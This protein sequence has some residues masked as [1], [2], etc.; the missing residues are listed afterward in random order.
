MDFPRLPRFKRSTSVPAIQ[1]TERDRTIIRSIY[2]HRFLRSSHIIDLT[3]G[4]RQA[5]LRRLQLLYHHGYLERPRAQI[6][7]YR[8]GGSRHMVYGLGNK[9]AAPLKPE[10][11][12][13]QGVRWS[14]K[15]RSIRRLFF[16]HVIAVS[17][18]MVALELACRKRSDV[19]LIGGH[20]LPIPG[21]AQRRH[22]FKW[23]VQLNNH[24][25][26]G[27]LPDRVFALEVTKEDGST[28]RAFFFLE[29]DRGTMPIV[30]KNLSQTSFY[31]KLLAYEATW[32][33]GLHR[34][35]FGFHRFR[36]LTVTTSAA[37]VKSLVDACSQLKSGHGLFLFCDQGTLK[38]NGD[39]L[40][41]PWKTGRGEAT[42]ILP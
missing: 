1:L 23:R 37:R 22:P 33:S 32:S 21:E 29:V 11:G 38:Q 7:Y 10:I 18:V 39:I 9:G 3:G 28:G 12:I 16:E 4:S 35:K 20:D 8:H 26:L 2:Q 15:N 31:R 6:E 27:I 36:V 13:S 17:D 5:V 42:T 30:R 19:R 41:V 25:K 34:L 14:E 40:T 24:L